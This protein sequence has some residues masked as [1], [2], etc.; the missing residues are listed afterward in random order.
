MLDPGAISVRLEWL[1]TK[2]YFAVLSSD[3]L[4]FIAGRIIARDFRKGE[5]IFA[6]GE[7]CPGLYIVYKGQVRVYKLSAEGREQVLRNFNAGQSFNEVAVFDRSI[8]CTERHD[9]IDDGRGCS[10]GLLLQT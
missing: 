8:P 5:Q 1:R 6:E 2:P 7:P 9:A 4:A 10:R 3:D